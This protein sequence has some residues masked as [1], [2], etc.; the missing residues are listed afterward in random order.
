MRCVEY[1]GFSGYIILANKCYHV[2]CFTFTVRLIIPA[3]LQWVVIFW[4]FCL[5]V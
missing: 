4:L 3:D 2:V 5:G 1:L